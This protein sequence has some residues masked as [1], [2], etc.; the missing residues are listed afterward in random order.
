MVNII[1]YDDIHAATFKAMNLARLDA[2]G[3]TESH[4]LQ[5]L[6][7]PRGTIIKHGGVIYLAEDAGEIAG[8]AAI[9][10]EGDGV[11]ELM[12]MTVADKWRGKGI[13]KMLIEKCIDYA[14]EK[15]GSKIILFSSSK[16]KTAIELYKKYGF[17]HVAVTDSP[18]DTADVKMELSL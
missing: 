11:F 18:F 9:M 2:D 6:D 1:D 12:K 7:D 3:L 5:I 13:S 17:V 15:G 4:D 14:K 16:P 8:S 10:P